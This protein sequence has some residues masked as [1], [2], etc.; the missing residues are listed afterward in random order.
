M[1]LQ[2]ERLRGH[3]PRP[4]KGPPLPSG[5]RDGLRRR[6]ALPDGPRAATGSR[7]RPADC[8]LL[9]WAAHSKQAEGAAGDA[10]HHA[11]TKGTLMA[12]ISQVR[13]QYRNVVVS[14]TGVAANSNSPVFHSFGYPV[15]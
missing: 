7:S 12:T 10:G 14:I 3:Q 6:P 5:R 1:A 2:G 8:Y 11:T 4:R 9:R 15:G 13:D